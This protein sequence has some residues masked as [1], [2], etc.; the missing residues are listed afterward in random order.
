MQ[1]SVER[2]T[3]FANEGC[4]GV[5]SHHRWRKTAVILPQLAPQLPSEM[6]QAIWKMSGHIK[7]RFL[8]EDEIVARLGLDPHEVFIDSEVVQERLAWL[9]HH[10][11]LSSPPTTNVLDFLDEHPRKKLRVDD[12]D[13]L[14]VS[15]ELRNQVG[16]FTACRTELEKRI[17]LHTFHRGALNRSIFPV[18]LCYHGT[19]QCT[20][21]M[22]LETLRNIVLGG[23]GGGEGGG[24]GGGGG[25]GM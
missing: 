23:G 15:L 17:V 1:C 24:G 14:M 5:C 7:H 22:T 3:F 18:G 9:R 20:S 19:P 21:T 16:F 2:C 13:R 11:T 4:E 12:A 8:T 25:G 10:N 6:L